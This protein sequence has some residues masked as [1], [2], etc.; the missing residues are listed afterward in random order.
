[1]IS[2][3]DIPIDIYLNNHLICDREV[4]EPNSQI[5]QSL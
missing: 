5:L 3:T 1:M 4:T 2:T